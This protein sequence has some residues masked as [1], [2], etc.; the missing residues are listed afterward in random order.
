MLSL[1][2]DASFFLQK[3]T[4]ELSEKTNHLI[5]KTHPEK[6]ETMK[7]ARMQANLDF[8][9]R[10]ATPA[11]MIAMKM[12][13]G[14]TFELK[15]GAWWCHRVLLQQEDQGVKIVC[16]GGQIFQASFYRFES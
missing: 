9:I 12:M 3:K 16:E 7:Q 6:R 8:L 14:A 15:D 13:V 5:S 2:G 4:L 1:F 10:D 11:V